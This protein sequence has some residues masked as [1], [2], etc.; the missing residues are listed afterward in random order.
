MGIDPIQFNTWETGVESV[1]VNT[2]EMGLKPV[3]LNTWVVPIN[4]CQK[5]SSGWEYLGTWVQNHV[6]QNTDQVPFERTIQ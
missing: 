6:H 4:M 5:S 2:L 1:Q 3:W